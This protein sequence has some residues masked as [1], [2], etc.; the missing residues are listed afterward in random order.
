MRRVGDRALDS[1]VANRL[2]DRA[3][4]V[5]PFAPLGHSAVWLA[6]ISDMYGK[7]GSRLTFHESTRRPPRL[8][9]IATGQNL[10]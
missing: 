3:A 9:F 8:T 6:T 4:Q 5:W 10:L 1:T 2:T 7:R